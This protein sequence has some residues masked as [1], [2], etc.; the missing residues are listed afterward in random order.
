MFNDIDKM[1]KLERLLESRL[2]TACEERL[3][4]VAQ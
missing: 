2:E 3:L 1:C 4:G